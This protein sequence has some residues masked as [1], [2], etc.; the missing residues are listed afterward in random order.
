MML[1]AEIGKAEE[2]ISGSQTAIPVDES[3][4]A[5]ML[6]CGIYDSGD[7]TFRVVVMD[8]EKNKSFALLVGETY[9]SG[10]EL[11]DVDYNK[12]EVILKK[13]EE[14]VILSMRGNAARKR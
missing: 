12:E 2:V 1:V 6:L 13:G 4:A 5:Q 14:V 11:L 9:A 7:G 3:F 8:K 10:I